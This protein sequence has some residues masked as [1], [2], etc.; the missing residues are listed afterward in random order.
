[1]PSW[2]FDSNSGKQKSNA[3]VLMFLKQGNSVIE[4]NGM[5]G[6]HSSKYFAH[7]SSFNPYNYL[8]K[9]QTAL[10]DQISRSVVSDS[11]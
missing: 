5:Q 11:L 1:M 4:S 2:S 7:M 10:S 6:R 3:N 9:E 8:R